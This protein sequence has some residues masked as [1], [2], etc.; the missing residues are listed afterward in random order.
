MGQQSD[1]DGGFRVILSAVSEF[2]LCTNR[3]TSGLS[4]KQTL[5]FNVNFNVDNKIYLRVV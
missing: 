1:K 4:Q 3:C 2:C 5:K